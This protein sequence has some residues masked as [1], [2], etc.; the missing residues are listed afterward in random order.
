MCFT[1]KKSNNGQRN[2]LS[3]LHDDASA[4]MRSPQTSTVIKLCQTQWNFYIYDLFKDNQVLDP[5]TCIK[6]GIPIYFVDHSEFI[7]VQ[8][9]KI[10]SRANNKRKCFEFG[11]IKRALSIKTSLENNYSWINFN[12]S[13]CFPPMGK[14]DD[15]IKIS[16][17]IFKIHK[18]SI[19]FVNEKIVIKR[20]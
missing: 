19:K 16:Y 11:S 18:P 6:L 15:F 9:K 4:G 17:C 13:I 8:R 3:S 12:I 14:H 1:F 10:L 7:T 20:I 2:L 5:V